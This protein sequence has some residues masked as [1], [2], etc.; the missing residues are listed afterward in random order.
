[1][2]SRVQSLCGWRQQC[3][4]SMHARRAMAV[5]I[6]ILTLP[7]GATIYAHEGHDHDGPPPLNLPVAPR[8]VAVTPDFEL[9]G[10]L[11]GKNRLTIFLHRF[12]TN[13]PVK[14]AKLKVSAGDE[15]IAATPNGDGVFEI[16]APWITADK[17]VDLIFQ[18]SL[19]NTEDLLTGRLQ[20]VDVLGGN[21]VPDTGDAA[22]LWKQKNTIAIAVG[23]FLIGMFFALLINW[24]SKTVR[25]HEASEG[26]NNSVRTAVRKSASSII[27]AMLVTLASTGVEP[28][29]AK[30]SRTTVVPLPTMATDTPQ[31][32]PDG[33][34]FVPKATQHLLSIRTVITKTA[35]APRTT[36]LVGTIIA[37][38]RGFGRVQPARPGR[39]EA[40][41]KGLAFV[42]KPVQKGEVLAYL[43]PYIEAAD[44]ATILSQIAET[45][46][47]I[48]KLTTILSRFKRSRGA[49]PQIKVDEVAGELEALKRKRSELQPSLRTREEIRSPVSGIVSSSTVVAGQIVNAREVLFEIINPKQFWVEAIAYDASKTNNVAK[50]IAIT[51]NGRQLPLIFAGQGLSLKQ[52]AIPVMFRIT[53]KSPGLSIGAPVTVILQSKQKVQGIVLPATSVVTAPSGLSIVWVKEDAERFRPQ[54]VRLHN[55]NGKRIVIRSGI[56]AGLRVVTEGAMLL[57]QV[58]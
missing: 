25:D 32:M 49:V 22:P 52:Q 14:E 4:V 58:R 37:D 9:V 26:V 31:R 56:K 6:L 13:E 34:L 55:L 7:F 35:D 16:S 8:L 24:R 15:Q 44:K 21:K 48:K 53:Q 40:P 50:A 11:S 41:A 2:T 3:I 20:S 12:Q 30:T 38:P 23:A 43:A 17:P 54:P 18:L 28:V 47:R 1:M 39:I 46:A 10:V 36:E 5:L 33:T 27:L 42:G 19:P 29:V 51:N 57:N 45:E